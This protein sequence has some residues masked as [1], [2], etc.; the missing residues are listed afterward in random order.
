MCS[1]GRIITVS[2]CIGALMHRVFLCFLSVLFS[3][4]FA[5]AQTLSKVSDPASE[6]SSQNPWAG[7]L[8]IDI[9]VDS[10]RVYFDKD[11]LDKKN[12]TAGS[13]KVLYRFPQ[14]PFS[15]GLSYR[16]VDKEAQDDKV[17]RQ[18]RVTGFVLGTDYF[19][20]RVRLFVQGESGQG[21]LKVT[22]KPPLTPVRLSRQYDVGYDDLRLGST[23]HW[24]TLYAGAELEFITLKSALPVAGGGTHAV[25][26]S[27][28]NLNAI[29]GVLL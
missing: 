29:V 27:V 9:R 12:L 15:L 24:S 17:M 13:A 10:N 26:R 6:T 22:A 14:F 19:I 20:G 4:G 21:T 5:S 28:K 23:Y 2:F 25:S 18:T 7:K 11:Y 16:E 8:G 1:M 3:S